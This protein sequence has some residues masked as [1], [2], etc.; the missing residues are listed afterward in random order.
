MQQQDEQSAA[1]ATLGDKHASLRLGDE[2][3][4]RQMRASLERHGQLSALCAYRTEA[5][6]L[7]LVD[8]FKRLRAARELGWK[9][10]RVRTLG[11]DAVKAASS[12][13][14][15]NEAHGLTELEEGW[16]CRLLH[17][18]HG[19]PQHEVGRWVGRHKSWVCRRLLL[20]EALDD[21]VQA[22]VRLGL[23]AARTAAELARLPRGNQ[24]A[25]AEVVIRRGLTTAQ[26]ASLVRAVLACPDAAMRAQR[27]ADALTAAEP[28]LRAQA[29][30]LQPVSPADALL[31]DI[32]AATRVS[33]RLQARL[34]D[35]P[36]SA[37]EPR[38]AAL[39]LEGMG[40]LSAVIGRLQRTLELTLGGKDLRCETLE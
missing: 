37:W 22:Q 30:R 40:A 14:I 18:D 36:M 16:I 29:A 9:Q 28:L 6:E 32:D 7:E 19:L 2:G 35:T 23:V 12:M 34:R 1:I 25:A 24:A 38:A 4:M 13:L 20:V 33:A 3:A 27:L 10:L 31:R 26:T 17:R 15:L 8:G 11:D 39:L 21:S 5:H